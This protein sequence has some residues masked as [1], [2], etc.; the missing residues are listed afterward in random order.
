M[1]PTYDIKKEVVEPLVDFFNEEKI[2]HEFKDNHLYVGLDKGKWDMC[3]E[4][5]DST[6]TPLPKAFENVLSAIITKLSDKGVFGS[7]K[8]GKYLTRINKSASMRALE[9]FIVKKHTPEPHCIILKYEDIV[10]RL[11]GLFNC[12]AIRNFLSKRASF[13]INTSTTKESGSYTYTNYSVRMQIQNL[14]TAP[15]LNWSSKGDYKGA[16]WKKYFVDFFNLQ[17]Q[18]NKVRAEFPIEYTN[19]FTCVDCQEDAERIV[20]FIKNYIPN[21]YFLLDD[22]DFYEVL[23]DNNIPALLFCNELFTA[24]EY[25]YSTG[26]FVGRGY[27][28]IPGTTEHVYSIKV[29]LEGKQSYTIDTAKLLTDEEHF[30]HA[31]KV[32]NIIFHADSYELSDNMIERLRIIFKIISYEMEE[33]G[34]GVQ[35]GKKGVKFVKGLYKALAK[36]AAANLLA[37]GL[38]D[39]YEYNYTQTKDGFEI[40]LFD[41]THALFEREFKYKHFSEEYMKLDELLLML[42]DHQDN[43]VAYEE[44]KEAIENCEK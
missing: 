25:F 39:D 12:D 10:T 41:G 17:Q 7:D 9:L 4:L 23:E 33:N 37:A 19:F 5:S 44:I 15:V 32:I 36:A 43:T 2:T 1:E 14:Y 21:E 34:W 8:V 16:A 20:E 42:A 24:M 35:I 11:V 30:K 26:G 18:R 31:L 13:T 22:I 6:V 27:T 28:H 3:F 38:P 29:P 40:S